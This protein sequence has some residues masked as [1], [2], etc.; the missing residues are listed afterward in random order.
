MSIDGIDAETKRKI[1]GILEL[2]FPGAKVYLY[3]SRARGD[4]KPNSDI[5][6]A[7]DAHNK[8]PLHLGEAQGLLSALNTPYSVDLV[9]IN[10]ASESFK[11]TITKDWVLWNTK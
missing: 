9:D 1:V 5:D 7:L 3:G 11:S 8:K 6:I 4:F 2:L 10:F